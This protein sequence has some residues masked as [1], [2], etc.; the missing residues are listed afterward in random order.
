MNRHN[1]RKFLKIAVFGA[2]AAGLAACVTTTGTTTPSVTLS[3]VLTDFTNGI[4][5]TLASLASLQISQPNMIPSGTYNSLVTSLNQA[6]NVLGTITTSLDGTTA[7]TLL[8]TVY[9]YINAFLNGVASI[10]AT[11]PSPF[12]SV[13]AALAFL[14]PEIEAYIS[15]VLGSTTSTSSA[16]TVWYSKFATPSG[17]NA[18]TARALLGSHTV[19]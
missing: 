15:S 9:G 5:T 7:A 1:R 16:A 12:G 11:L 18:N 10:S 17:L 14:A 6:K 13:V 4:N 19:S 8:E 3:Q 2:A